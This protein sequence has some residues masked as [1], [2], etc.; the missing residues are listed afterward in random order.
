MMY[1]RYIGEFRDVKNNLWEVKIMQESE[2][3]FPNI[4]ILSFPYET[5]LEIEWLSTSKEEVVCGSIATLTLLSPNDRTYEDLYSIEVGKIR[6]EVYKNTMLYWSGILDTEF[7]E[8]PYSMMQD[9]EVSFTFSDFGIL[10]RLKFDLS[11]ILSLEEIINYT[12]SRSKIIYNTLNNEFITTS[13]PSL[14]NSEL[15]KDLSIRA[16]NFYDEDGEANTLYE[17]IEGILQPLALRIIQKNGI[18]YIYYLNGA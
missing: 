2:S 3:S 5:P 8:E 1:A 10:D 17:V 11:G 7:Y 12:L 6:L 14:V 4:G 16:D 13:I 15:L 18:I 9:Y